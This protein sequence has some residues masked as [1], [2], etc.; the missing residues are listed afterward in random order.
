MTTPTANQARAAELH[1]QACA[2][3][4]D[5]E[6]ALA[7]YGEVLALD[8]D[9]PT[10]HYNIGLIYKYQGRWQESFAHNSRSVALAPDDEAANWNLAIAATALRNWPAARGVWHRLGLPIEPG[11]SPIEQD[12]G[13]TPVRLNPDDKAEVV[14]GRRIDPVRVRIESIPLPDSGYRCGD[15][16]LH[17]GAAVGYR[18]LG[19]QDVPV[20]NVLALFQTSRHSTF[21]AEVQAGSQADI[22]ALCA[23]LEKADVTYE[24]WTTNIRALCKQCSEGVPHDHDGE[25]PPTGFVDR[26]VVGIA[27]DQPEAVQAL[28]HRWR[29]AGRSVLRFERMLTPP[30]RH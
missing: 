28:L 10:T 12:F 22:D 26:H 23:A 30:V 24:D 18:K 17:D 16:V 7:M 8:P 15:V 11:D 6:A 27:T 14:W 13:L 21:E 2:L 3:D 19:D 29:G 4:D 1:E 20:F 25:E 9:R 5:D